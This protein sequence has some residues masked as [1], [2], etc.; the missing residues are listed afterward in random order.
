M[1][2]R[3]S[4]FFSRTHKAIMT[5]KISLIFISLFLLLILNVQPSKAA[6]K[7]DSGVYII[8]DVAGIAEIGKNKKEARENAKH[9]ASQNA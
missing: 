8:N 9:S 6:V 4:N 1:Y 3:F 2:S 5:K 7:L